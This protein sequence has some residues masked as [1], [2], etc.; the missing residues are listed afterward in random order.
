MTIHKHPISQYK[1]ITLGPPPASGLGGI[2]EVLP[3]YQES[4]ELICV[5]YSHID[6]NNPQVL[7]GRCCLWLRTIP[8][9]VS[10]ILSA[11]KSGYK[12]IVYAHPGAGYSLFR[13]SALLA[14]SRLLGAKTILHVHAGEVAEYL[15]HKIP[16]QLLMLALCRVQMLLVLTPWW[17]TLLYKHNVVKNVDIVPNPIPQTLL[18]C[19]AKSLRARLTTSDPPTT[20]E[21]LVMTRLVAGKGIRSTLSA[22]ALL[23]DN[24]FLTIAGTGPLH[25]E[26][27]KSIK[28][29]G[30][31]N[32]VRL[33]G[34]VSGE[35]RNKLYQGANV[36]CMPSRID[37]FGMGY[38]EAMAFGLPVVA[39]RWGPIP[40]IVPHR[41][42]GLLV[43]DRNPQTIADTIAE[44]CDSTTRLLDMGLSGHELVRQTY[45]TNVVSNQLASVFNSL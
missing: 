37:S 27:I 6:I 45:S 42:V 41:K 21:I 20:I 15:A 25:G 19:G 35:A 43:E 34:W 7:G 10:K 8:S 23:P 40:D 12:S 26:L 29:L 33:I 1:I 17:K 16:K 22:L 32:R 18:E 36:Y 39:Y 5:G 28:K 24:Y 9:L 38:I 2:S 14:V 30:L 3:A 11:K 13:A 4:I 31:K 44:L